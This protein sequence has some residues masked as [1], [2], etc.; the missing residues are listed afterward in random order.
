VISLQL[1]IFHV[2]PI[3]LL[4]GGHLAVLAIESARRKDLSW[5]TKERIL[6]VGFWLIVA[7]VV[8]VVYNDIMKV[9]PPGLEKLLP[10]T[11]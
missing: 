2:L 11:K 5:R 8:L 10:W 4:D 3:P 7:L 6:N 9:L 1:A